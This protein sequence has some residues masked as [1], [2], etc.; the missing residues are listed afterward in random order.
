MLKT[1]ACGELR[2][3]HVAQEVTLAGWVHRRRDHGGLI[4]VDLRD[5]DGIVQVVFSPEEAP[6]AH[7][8]ADEVRNE[9]VLQVQGVV[10][11]RPAGTENRQLPTGEVE[12]RAQSA[13]ILNAAK[14]PPF[15]I[16]EEQEVDELLRLRY[17]YLDLRRQRL[18]QNIVLRHRVVKYI[19]DFLSERSFTEIETPILIKSTPEGARDYLVPS[20]INP[21]RFYALPQSPQQLKQLLMVAGFERYFQIARCFRDEDLRADRQPEFTQLD[22]EMS[23]VAEEDVLALMEELHAGLAQ[24]VR[25]DLRTL[26]PFPRLTYDEAMRR[27]GTDKPDLRYGMELAD[28][29]DILAQ[30]ELGIFRETVATGG[31]VKAIAVPGAATF[32]RRQIDELTTFVQGYG[33]RGLV[34]VALAGEGPIDGLAEADIHS[35]MR[36][37]L[38][39]DEV[40]TMAQRAQAHRG[41]LLI[42]IADKEAI[43]HTALDGMRREMA[44]RL[45]LA[46]E[47]ILQFCF[48]TDFPLVQWN[49]E[50][51]RWDSVHHPFTSPREEDLPLLRTDPGRVRARAY[52]IVG[53]GWEVG[54]GSIR[55]HRRQ[56]QEEVFRLLGIGPEQAQAHFGHL[57]EAFEYGAPPHGGIATGIDRTAMLL[58]GAANIREIIAF[59]KTQ[60][61]VDPLFSAP[62][63]VS[64]QQL[65]ELHLKLAPEEGQ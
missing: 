30:S 52:D 42:L 62:S 21:G 5:H 13:E 38:R 41:D 50:E 55:I 19:R 51:E 37:Y 53:N 43:V 47:G 8:V 33:A 45:G 7:A 25:P 46:D 27:F 12:V 2:P 48:V 28:L 23:F 63:P 64:P 57:L 20:R 11:R 39:L 35:P 17:R 10:A 29:S 59:P 16:N 58:A 24:A 14:T 65:A 40:V 44:R 18:H 6:T 34:S 49:A 22:L 31:K 54:G 9:Y 26:T 60:S 3:H 56:V 4:F 32:S 15:Y 36:R 61:A 1:H